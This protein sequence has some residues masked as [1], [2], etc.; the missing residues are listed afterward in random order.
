MSIRSYFFR[1]NLILFV[2]VGFAVSSETRGEEEQN[3]PTLTF[4]SAAEDPLSNSLN[5][6]FLD[7]LLKVALDRVGYSLVRVQLPAERALRD[8]NAGTLDGEF[9]RIDGIQNKYPNLIRVDEKIMDLDFVAFS[10]QALDTSKGWEVLAPLNVA[11]LSGW[12]IIETNVPKQSRIT[13]VNTP[14]QLFHM[15]YKKR[16]DVI[17]YERWAGLNLMTNDPTYRDIKV[18]LPPLA[19]REMYCYVNKKHAQVAVKLAQTLK[20]L[21]ENG[22][23]TK[24]YNNTLH[25][26]S[27]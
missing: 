23:Y 5:S 27:E 19:T 15:L 26:L 14:Y 24:I 13:K 18:R 6:G 3:R 12:K 1:F 9:I 17:I 2:I 20:E 25:R 22:T 11:F 16:V 7:Q 4:N 8:V 10:E 21:K